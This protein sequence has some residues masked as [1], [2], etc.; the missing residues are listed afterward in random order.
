MKNRHQ[1]VEAYP[2]TKSGYKLAQTLSKNDKLDINDLPL[3]TQIYA[4]LFEGK[5]VEASISD[6]F[7]A[8]R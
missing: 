6:Y 1:T 3:L 7:A 4:V 5:D 2:A 8:L